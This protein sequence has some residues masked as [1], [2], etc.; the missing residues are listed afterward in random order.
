ML[1]DSV[2]AAPAPG[3]PKPAPESTKMV[4]EPRRAACHRAALFSRLGKIGSSWL[5]PVPC[6]CSGRRELR[7]R[8]SFCTVRHGTMSGVDG[9][10][11]IFWRLLAPFF[12]VLHYL[13]PHE[14][15]RAALQL[16]TTDSTIL[17]RDVISASF[18]SLLARCDIYNPTLMIPASKDYKL[19]L[20]KSV[21][22]IP[23]SSANRDSQ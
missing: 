10:E 3:R 14:P 17:P 13:S 7:M 23:Y 11:S 16:Y 12:L 9:A 5:K 6:C 20:V 19:L 1:Y 18:L 15:T 21:N 2:S 22:N 4:A 8:D